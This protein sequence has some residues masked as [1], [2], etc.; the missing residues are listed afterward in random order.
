MLNA[1]PDDLQDDLPRP[2]RASTTTL[3]CVSALVKRKNGG[4]QHPKLTAVDQ[5]SQPRQ[6]EPIRS[7][8]EGRCL[9]TQLRGSV[10]RR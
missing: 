8:D 3:E 6:L 10:L 9:D 7:D 4:D 2:T 5:S 1:V